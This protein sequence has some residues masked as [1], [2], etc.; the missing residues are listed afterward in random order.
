MLTRKAALKFCAT[1]A[2]GLDSPEIIVAPESMAAYVPGKSAGLQTSAAT[3]RAGHERRNSAILTCGYQ[4]A[5]SLAPFQ[6]F[7]MRWWSG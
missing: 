1:L 2:A 7:Q 5:S 6:D 4:P 3:H